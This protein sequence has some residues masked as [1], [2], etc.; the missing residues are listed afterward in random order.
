M[1][2]NFKL[3]EERLLR[4]LKTNVFAF[5]R[6][7][8]AWFWSRN[9]VDCRERSRDGLRLSLNMEGRVGS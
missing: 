4:R 7:R 9:F 6:M 1:P 8:T 5:E 2:M 3:I